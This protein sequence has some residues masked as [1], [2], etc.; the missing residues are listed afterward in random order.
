MKTDLSDND[1]ASLG[2]ILRSGAPFA[3]LDANYYESDVS[4]LFIEPEKV[5]SI[6][7][8]GD[9]RALMA[10]LEQGLDAGLYAAGYLGYESA[11]QF[12]PH[13]PAPT[14]PTMRTVGF[15]LFRR[16]VTLTRTQTE[17]LMQLVADG[18]DYRLVIDGQSRD[19]DSYC[20]DLKRLQEHI[21]AGDTY[22]T[23][24]T[25]RLTG[26]MQ[27]DAFALYEALRTEQPVSFGAMLAFPDTPMMLSRSPELFFRKTADQ[28]VTMP[29][30]G[31]APRGET[32]DEDEAIVAALLADEK[33]R[34]E[35]TIIV[36]LLRND[37]GRVAAVNSVSVDAYLSTERYKSV[38]QL[39]ST[40]SATVKEDLSLFDLIAGIFPCGSVT[41]APKR[42]TMQI[43]QDLEAG[44]RGIYT[45]SI[46]YIMPNRD[47]CM[48]VAIRTLVLDADGAV[49][50]GV[51]GG[52]VHESDGAAEYTECHD[53]ARFLRRVVQRSG[54]DTKAGVA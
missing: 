31:T 12:D 30:K 34:S 51:G 28:I 37:F 8:D 39:T 23:N 20:N 19:F 50:M 32:S 14:A 54:A 52:I 38:H 6:N 4:Y 48:N 21:T 36:D 26:R 40:I 22:Q 41:G 53:K 9:A 27:G 5:L 15:G 44:S 1:L 42:R 49:E 46:G 2:A 35:N 29:M 33:T 17:R 45:G 11:H 25:F 3:L 43:I 7:S 13:L 10:E 47:I 16:Y 24:Y 18:H